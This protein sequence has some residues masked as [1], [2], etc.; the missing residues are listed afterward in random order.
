VADNLRH[1]VI[2]LLRKR[3]ASIELPW[4]MWLCGTPHIVEAV[5]QL[6]AARGRIEAR[7]R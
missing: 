5:E 2:G 1:P 3:G 4:R 6:A 7:A